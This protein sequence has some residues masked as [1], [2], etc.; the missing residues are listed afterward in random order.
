VLYDKYLL[1]LLANKEPM[2]YEKYQKEF[3]QFVLNK[4]EKQITLF[5]INKKWAE[6]LD[7]VS[8]IREGIH[9]VVIGGEN[10]LHKFHSATIEAF[11]EVLDSIE[12]DII[13]TFKRVKPEL[14]MKQLAKHA[15]TID[16]P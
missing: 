4:V 5:H 8:Y 15:V 7:Y 12:I 1:T 11:N 3:G 13:E 6:Y 10:P 9:L 2:L 14:F 16:I